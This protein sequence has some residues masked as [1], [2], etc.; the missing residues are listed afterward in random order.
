MRTETALRLPERLRKQLGT[1]A[2]RGRV[3]SI[4][5]ARGLH[6]VCEEARCPNIGEC[7]ASGTAT[8][9]ILGDRCTRRC[10]FCSVTTARPR[11]V[12]P[13]EPA[14]LA[15]AA[16]EMGLA[17]VVI[18]SVDRDDLADKGAAHFAACIR[19]VRA[20]LPSAKVEVLT[21]DFAG[22]PRL[23]DVVLDAQPD[24]FNHNTE[25]VPRLYRAVRPQSRWESTQSVLQHAAAAGHAC[26]KSGIMV[27][28]GETDDEV[29]ATLDGM[30]ALGVHV[31]TIGQYLRPSLSHWP[32]ARYVDDDAYERFRAH[33]AALGF[34]AVF[35]GAF[36]RSSYH[37]GETHQ[38][39][40]RA[41]SS[42]LRVLP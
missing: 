40:S 27:G 10:H 11:Q 29:L 37:A 7:F 18:T 26:V 14:K 38:V 23:V 22:D 36:V 30:R 41:R 35:A 24:V 13:D 20:A 16:R 15:D 17:H 9:M 1:T 4:M 32:V 12:D 5:R 28:L 3:H 6:T 39:H 19:A 31:A 2:Q 34:T 8:F 33:G 25:T 21:P 42:S